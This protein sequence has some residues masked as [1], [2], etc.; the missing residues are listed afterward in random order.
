MLI[1]DFIRFV[2]SKKNWG[3]SEK[4]HLFGSSAELS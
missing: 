1:I 4:N 3:G 2:G